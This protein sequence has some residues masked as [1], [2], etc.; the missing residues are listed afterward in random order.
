[1]DTRAL[2]HVLTHSSDYQKPPQV[3]YNLARILGE[4]AYQC[5][6]CSPAVS[7]VVSGVLFVEGT[8]SAA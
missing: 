7:D 8:I 1:M 6:Y 3:R 2:N 5:V 4:G